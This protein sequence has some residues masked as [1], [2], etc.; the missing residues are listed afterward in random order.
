M[1]RLV[2]PVLTALTIFCPE[3]FMSTAH[4]APSLDARIDAAAKHVESS[5]IATRRDIHEHPELGNREVRTAKLVAGRLQALGI[6]T[7]TGV[8]H[9]G[10]IGIL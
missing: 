3:V 5:V 9:T 6:E 7:K 4:A 1:R 10:V 8:A 2:L